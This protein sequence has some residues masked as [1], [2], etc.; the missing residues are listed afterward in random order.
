MKKVN[1]KCNRTCKFEKVVSAKGTGREEKVIAE[2]VGL[3]CKIQ[4]SSGNLS[5]LGCSGT[6]L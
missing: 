2:M 3:P 5:D 1:D 4:Q 6:L